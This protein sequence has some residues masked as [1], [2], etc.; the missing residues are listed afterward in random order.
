MIVLKKQKQLFAHVTSHV[1]KSEPDRIKCL[2]L[3]LRVRYFVKKAKRN[4]TLSYK[5]RKR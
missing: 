3:S 2:H 1:S 4:L 5:K